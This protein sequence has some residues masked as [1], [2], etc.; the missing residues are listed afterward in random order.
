MPEQPPPPEDDA[1]ADHEDPSEDEEHGRLAAVQAARRETIER[2]RERGVPAFA[3]NF[4]KDA[5]AAE[6]LAEY[7][8]RLEPG[9]ETD[10]ERSVAGRIVL[11]RRHGGV[12]FVVIRDRS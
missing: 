4:D 5:D 1:A 12:A 9:E 6:I 10:D 2:L 3:L 7:D 11:L 8:G